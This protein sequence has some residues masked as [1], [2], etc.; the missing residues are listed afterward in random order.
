MANIEKSSRATAWDRWFT[1]SA[2][3]RGFD[4]RRHGRG[5]AEEYDRRSVAWQTM[6][7]SGRLFAASP[8]SRR[9]K[10]M[11]EDGRAVSKTLITAYRTME[12]RITL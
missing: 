2:F 9:W 10:A 6:Y 1:D 4:D 11:P 8:A 5:F 7:E 12:G 3:R